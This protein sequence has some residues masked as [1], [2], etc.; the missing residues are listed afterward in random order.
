[1]K[2]KLPNR[3][4]ESERLVCM[5]L[6]LTEVTKIRLSFKVELDLLEDVYDG[7]QKLN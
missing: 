7:A 6:P 3:F 2:G 4:H 5:E 1:M